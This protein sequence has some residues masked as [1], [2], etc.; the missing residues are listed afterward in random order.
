MM[1]RNMKTMI[2]AAAA[3]AMLAPLGACGSASADSD[4][5]TLTFFA[6]NTQ[7]AYQ[8]V[9][10]AFA[11]KYPDIKVKFSTT[12]GSQGGYQQVLQTRISGGKLTDVF[13]LPPE[14]LSDMVDNQLALDLTDEAFMKSIPEANKAPYSQDGKTYG[15]S[16]STWINAL[17]FNKD[18]LKKA[19]YDEIPATWDEFIGMLKKI[20]KTEPDVTP[21]LEAKDGLGIPVEGW[22][23]EE[24]AAD[25]DGKML[26]QSITDGE[27]TFE[28]TYGP[29]YTEWS[30]LFKED[31]MTSD[32]TGISADQMR[33]EFTSGRL[34]VM[35]SGA[36]DVP[37]FKDSGIDFEFGTVPMLTKDQE[38][39]TP[40][41]ADPSFAINAKI[42][43]QKLENA[44]KFLAFLA[45][46]E[47]LK[48]YQEGT[49]NIP[50]VEGYDAEIDPSF[51]NVY[52][53]YMKTGH[54]YLNTLGWPAKG[55][56]A[57]RAETFS[58]LQQVAMGSID[59]TTA[60][61]NL[62]GKLQS[63]K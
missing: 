23:G 6:N 57:L 18:L 11:K 42:S 47:G 30:K 49:G 37:T 53:T 21:Y 52:D 4:P 51:Q 32:V 55:R 61:K 60:A 26:D 56:T 35:A 39:Y 48:A 12:N 19:G 28:K 59:G 36:W 3:V 40:G 31:V 63:Y 44:K 34:A 27:T 9:L 33:T 5:N 1:S 54:V 58:Q 50:V 2:A 38:Q 41:A 13:V 22:L 8:P 25:N 29:L 17:A 62:D 14:Q 20:K 45:S 10:D 7:D 16:V 24:S 46:P 43:G 15:M